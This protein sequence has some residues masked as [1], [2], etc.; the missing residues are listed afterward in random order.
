MEEFAMSVGKSVPRVDAF[1]KVTGRA[2]YTDDLIEKGALIA[3]V[4]HST[5]ANGIVVKMDISEASAIPGVVKIIT[6]FDVPDI[7]FATAGHP[8]ALEK[9]HQ[10]VADRHLLNRRVRLYGDDI[11]AVIAEDEVAASRALR[12]IKVEYEQ[13]P[14]VLSPEAAMAEGASQLHEDYP[15]NILAHTSFEDGDF[16][17]AILE[18][19]LIKIEGTYETPMVQHCHIELPISYA[20]MEAGRIV[21]VSATQIP[22]ITRRVVAQALGLPWGKIRVIKPYLGGGFGN[23]QDVLYEPLNAYLSQQVGGRLVK[24]ELTREETFYA[25]RVRHAMKF[26]LT[27]YVR[28]NGRIVARKCTVLSN[29]GAYASHGHSVASKSMTVFRQLYNDEKAKKVEGYTVYTNMPSAGAMRAYGVPQAI[30]AVES[31]AED[32]ITK[33]NLDP[34]RFRQMNMMPVGYHDPFSKNINYFDSFNQCMEKGMEYIGWDEKRALYKNQKGPVRRG[35]GMSLLWYNTGV[36]P[37]SLEVSS[38]RM[39]INEDGSLQMQLGETE[40]GQG[41]DTAFSQMAA[42]TLGVRFADV[43]IISTQ[44]T[45][46]T[47]FGL[48]AYGSRQTYV[49]GFAI[50]QTA[51]ILKEKILKYAEKLEHKMAC[52]MDIVESNIVLKSNGAVLRSLAALAE[53]AA[54]SMEHAEH[55]T[56]ESTYQCKSNA[57]SFGCSF[58]EVEVDIPLGKVKILDIINVHDCGQLINPQL[59]EAQVHGGMSMS[60]G[61]GLGE[62]MLF[63]EKTGRLLNDN[64]LDYKLGTLLDHPHLEAQFVE[65]YEPSSAYGTKG[66]GEPPAIPCASAIRNAVLNATGV[67]VNTIPLTP[68][69]LFPAF[70]DAGLI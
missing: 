36:W 69:R 34:I 39:L 9:S 48:G 60:I 22:H 8:W 49:A 18:E 24:L 53:E 6:C 54:Y 14:H 45:D 31:H 13:Y 26:H 63:D 20:Y 11:A 43:H 41:A 52:D 67:A 65:N 2:K 38:C 23:R 44:D 16:D 1:D 3:K 64:L 51:L 66:L 17:S 32:I 4:L 5:I 27:S 35:I 40:I 50:K 47:P 59:A 61:Y 15:K 37:I 7:P 25:T 46:T 12:A 28:P 58:A 57:Y 10:D 56:A 70:K 42:E 29:Q 19:G 55:L 68:H 33:L 21:V 30:F 62:Q